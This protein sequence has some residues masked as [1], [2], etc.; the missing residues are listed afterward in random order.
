[1]RPGGRDARAAVR[2]LRRRGDRPVTGGYGSAGRDEPRPW[3]PVGHEIRFVAAPLYCSCGW[4]PQTIERG[5]TLAEL[6]MLIA[7]H[8]SGIAP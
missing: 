5:H 1:V 4:A 8:E 2:R 6:I 7:Q 3:Q